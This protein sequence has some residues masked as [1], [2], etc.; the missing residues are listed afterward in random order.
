MRSGVRSDVLA[1]TP[2]GERAPRVRLCKSLPMRKVALGWLGSFLVVAGCAST[3]PL[4]D[5]PAVIEGV[6]TGELETGYL[7]SGSSQVVV[8]VERAESGEAVVA[9][10][11]FGEGEAPAPPTDPE[12]GWPEGVDPQLD[13]IPVADGFVYPSLDGSRSGDRISVDIAIT[14]LW[15]PWCA[16][17]TPHLIAESSDEAQC[18]PNRPWSASPFECYVEGEGDE[19]DDVLVDCLEL[20][21]CRRTRVCECTGTGGCVPSPTGLTMRLELT[22]D[23]DTAMGTIFWTSEDRDVGTQM[24]RVS[25]TRS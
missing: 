20:T 21:L 17:Q 19:A 7:P 22:V 5:G 6:W 2:R 25:F 23:G 16:L 4:P 15:A 3:D 13:A 9:S 12:V 8:D 18:L 24:A 11:I 10:V 14:D 1:L